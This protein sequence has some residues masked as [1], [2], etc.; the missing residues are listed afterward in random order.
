MSMSPVVH[1][2]NKTYNHGNITN[3]CSLWECYRSIYVNS[4]FL[5][6]SEVESEVKTDNGL[7]DLPPST[8][9]RISFINSIHFSL[10]Y[11]GMG[12]FVLYLN[13]QSLVLLISF[14]S[15]HFPSIQ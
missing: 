14:F 4:I 2:Q 5:S 6:F 9:D 7:D 3:L 8:G 12:V 13:F 1:T 11:L 10:D 15:I